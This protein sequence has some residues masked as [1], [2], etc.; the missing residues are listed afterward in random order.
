MY[1]CAECRKQPAKYYM[2]HPAS[3]QPVLVCPSCE[4]LLAARIAAKQARTPN[5][6]DTAGQRAT[7][8]GSNKAT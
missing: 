4:E 5:G 1:I 7:A 2:I 3:G 6:S 8:G